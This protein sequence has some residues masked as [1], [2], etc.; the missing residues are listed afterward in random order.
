M[1][2]Q[3]KTMQRVNVSTHQLKESTPKRRSVNRTILGRRRPKLPRPRGA[4]TFVLAL[5]VVVMR[6]QR[7]VWV[8]GPIASVRRARSSKARL[9]PRVGA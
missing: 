3:P 4:A 5:G 1:S 2:L 7:V 9:P 6:A 8:E